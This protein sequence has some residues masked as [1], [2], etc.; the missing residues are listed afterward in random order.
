MFSTRVLPQKTHTSFSYFSATGV[1][2][3]PIILLHVLGVVPEKVDNTPSKLY[4]SYVPRLLSHASAR[5]SLVIPF[6]RPERS[7]AA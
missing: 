1:Q 2:G 3:S 5:E 6:R 4:T 7:E